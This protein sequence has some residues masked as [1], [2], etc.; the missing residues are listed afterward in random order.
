MIYEQSRTHQY[1]RN[2]PGNFYYYVQKGSYFPNKFQ[3]IILSVNLREYFSKQQYQKCQKN[4]FKNE[5]YQ[6][7]IAEIN[8]LI[9]GITG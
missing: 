8:N 6:E 1:R 5:S 9:K 2:R 4:S 3:G 7:R